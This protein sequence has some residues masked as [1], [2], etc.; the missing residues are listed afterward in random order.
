MLVLTRKKNQSIFI[1][2]REIKITVVDVRGQLIRLGF[3]AD[4]S[5]EIVREEVLD[6]IENEG[7]VT[8]P[9]A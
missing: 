5:I 2:G 4:K 1:N 3:E 9:A 8:E 7:T 6:A